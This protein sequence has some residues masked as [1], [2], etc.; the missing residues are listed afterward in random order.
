VVQLEQEN[1]IEVE[2][3][4]SDS[5]PTEGKS[6]LLSTLLTTKLAEDLSV[7]PAYIAYS[8]M[9]SHVTVESSSGLSAHAS[10]DLRDP[11]NPAKFLYF[12]MRVQDHILT[13]VP[14]RTLTRIEPSVANPGGTSVFIGAMDFVIGDFGGSLNNLS[15]DATEMLRIGV[16][17]QLDLD[18]DGIMTNQP[19]LRSSLLG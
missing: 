18:A 17:L 16:T 5:V 15:S 2:Q 9:E 12:T 11:N 6:D 4:S 14:K 1:E 19:V 10:L 13:A 7:P 3:N 8:Q